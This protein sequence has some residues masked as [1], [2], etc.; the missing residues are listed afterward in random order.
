MFAARV[1]CVR[2]RKRGGGLG[3]VSSTKKGTREMSCEE[4]WS[5]ASLSTEEKEGVTAKMAGV[6]PSRGR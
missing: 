6:D 3:C 1:V 4:L 2:E 5:G